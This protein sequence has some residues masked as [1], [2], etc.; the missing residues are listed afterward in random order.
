MEEGKSKE[1]LVQHAENMRLKDLPK[2]L[3]ENITQLRQEARELN[4]GIQT[5]RKGYE[6]FLVKLEAFNIRVE[7]FFKSLLK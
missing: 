5:E 6:A 7:N 2:D 4:E 3:V 1:P